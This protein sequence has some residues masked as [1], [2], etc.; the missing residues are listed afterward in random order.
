MAHLFGNLFLYPVLQQIWVKGGY[1][2]DRSISPSKT[3]AA[4]PVM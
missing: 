4:G 1:K 2:K 3:V